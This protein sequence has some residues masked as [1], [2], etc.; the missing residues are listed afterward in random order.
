MHVRID[1]GPLD[2]DEVVLYL[3]AFIFLEI[4]ICGM[5]TN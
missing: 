5:Y 3:L 2:L 1:A 4:E